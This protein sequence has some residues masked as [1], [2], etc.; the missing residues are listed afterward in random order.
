[1][2]EASKQKIRQHHLNT[3]NAKED[4]HSGSMEGTHLAHITVRLDQTRRVTERQVTESTWD[5][6]TPGGSLGTAD[7]PTELRRRDSQQQR[8]P[9]ASCVLADLEESLLR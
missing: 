5:Y 7:V 1:M 9:A 4:F 2:Y 3:S 8:G 6:G